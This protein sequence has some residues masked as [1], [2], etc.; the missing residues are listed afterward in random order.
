MVVMSVQPSQATY[1]RPLLLDLE[2]SMIFYG[3]P[4]TGPRGKKAELIF[5]AHVAIHF[6]LFENVVARTAQLKSGQTTWAWTV[7]FS[8]ETRLRMLGDASR[9][10]RMPS[11]LPRLRVQFF[12]LRYGRDAPSEPH[13]FSILGLGA[14]IT[15]YSNGQEGCRYEESD[16]TCIDASLPQNANLPALLNRRSADFSTNYFSFTNS[17][18][19]GVL[20][21]R[22]RAVATWALLSELQ[23]HPVIAGFP[24]SIDRQ[25]ADTYGQ[26][27]VHV[28]VERILEPGPRRWRAQG[29][30][31]YAFGS[32]QDVPS[33]QAWLEG[34]IT[35]STWH[36][37]GVYARVFGG[38]DSYNAFF[39]DEVFQV[40]VGLTFDLAPPVV[41]GNR[42]S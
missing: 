24:G 38:R 19:F 15:H 22:R 26:A 2:R 1:E 27:V 12:R 14:G 36:G 7:L 21:E 13:R 35:W 6:H 41:F 31:T 39:V 28:A 23:L 18:R 10:V 16:G 5:D 33:V 30:T 32:A 8:L 11:Y 40:Q 42:A 20:N 29:G 17:Y 4:Y 3:L 9:P 37:V 25:T 34:A